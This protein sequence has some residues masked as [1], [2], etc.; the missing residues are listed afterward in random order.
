MKTLA[1]SDIAQSPKEIA[2]DLGVLPSTFMHLGAK[3]K[4]VMLSL[5][6]PDQAF[7]LGQVIGYRRGLEGGYGACALACSSESG[8]I[9]KLLSNRLD[10]YDYMWHFKE[11]VK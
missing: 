2:D 9:R 7:Q 3:E 5:L 10:G 1:H 6:T 8:V 4:G 11:R